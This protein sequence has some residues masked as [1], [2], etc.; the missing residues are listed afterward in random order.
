[1]KSSIKDEGESNNSDSPS[2]IELND[3]AKKIQAG[4]RGY[5]V[6]KKQKVE[7]DAAVTIQSHFRGFKTRQR[8]K[9]KST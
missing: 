7:R 1:M 2:E 3:S 6:R 4:M 9:Q 8:L 5:L